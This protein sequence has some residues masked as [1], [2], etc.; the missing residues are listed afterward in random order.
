MTISLGLSEWKWSPC[1]GWWT[2]SRKVFRP[3]TESELQ[4]KIIEKTQVK[5]WLGFNTATSVLTVHNCHKFI[6]TRLI[7]ILKSWRFQKYKYR[8]R[9][10]MFIVN[11]L[12]L[13]H[14]SKGVKR[15]YLLW[16]ALRVTK[17]HGEM[18]QSYH[19]APLGTSLS[20][21][22]QMFLSR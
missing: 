6:V 2:C 3:G 14:R 9:R 10:F 15:S 7:R 8:I 16:A 12:L 22:S 21:H 11:F 18:F 1:N 13:A 20:A 19:R 17:R 5:R 4:Y